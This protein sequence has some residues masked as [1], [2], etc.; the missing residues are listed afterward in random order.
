LYFI[1]VGIVFAFR[2]ALGTNDGKSTV[3]SAK[4]NV[5]QQKNY[6]PK[7]KKK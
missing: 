2:K 5:K 7:F 6:T 4:E 1:G 3:K